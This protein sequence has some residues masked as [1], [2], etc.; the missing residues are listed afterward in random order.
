M[1][2][3][4]WLVSIGFSVSPIHAQTCPAANFLQGNSVTVFPAD[5]SSVAGLQRQADGSFTRQRYSV[6]SPY[7]RLDSIANYQSSI[8]NCSA[9]GT[10]TFQTPPG[11]TPLADQPL[12][13]AQSMVVSDFLGNGS[14][15]GLAVVK[16]GYSAGPAV[17]SLLVVF[18]N[19]DGSAKSN[20]YYA[21]AAHPAGLVVADL[22]KD[23]KKA[24]V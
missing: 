13:P 23:G 2:R 9:A 4:L 8:L 5:R 20:A 24:L 21:V 16:G 7:K 14:P 19:A 22:N 12:A 10:R 15:V 1:K 18:F 6:F 3:L 17:D 11:W